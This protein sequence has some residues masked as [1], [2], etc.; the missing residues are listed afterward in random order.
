MNN[1]KLAELRELP[2]TDAMAGSSRVAVFSDTAVPVAASCITSGT[3]TLTASA[4]NTGV[5]SWR[6]IWWSNDG[7][8]TVT[9]A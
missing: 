3:I 4:T 7:T 5:I 6:V 9:A 8:G 1:E 2:F